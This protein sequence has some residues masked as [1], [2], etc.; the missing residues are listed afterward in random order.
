MT[1]PAPSSRRLAG[2]RLLARGAILFEA[3]WPALWPPIGLIG[4]FACAALLNLP[5]LL[6]PL[7]HLV[8][9][10]T[11]VLAV[12]VLA[13]RGL[14]GIRLP[15]DRAADRRLETSSGLIHR[16]LSVLTDR[17]A[18]GDSLGVAVWQAH[19]ARAMTQI[20]RLKVGLPRP[21]LARRDPRALRYGL[22]LCLLA[23]AV[24][25]GLDAP[26]RLLAALSPSLPV[27][28]NAP[29][30]EL[31]AWITAPAYTRVAPI[32]L[33]PPGGTVSVPAGSHLTVNVSGGTSAP[34]LSSNDRSDRFTALDHTSFQVER[35]LAHGGL[36]TVRRDGTTLAAWTLTV[37]ADQPPTAAWGENPGH[38]PSAQQTRLPWQVSDDY[39]VTGLQAELRLRDR[40]EAPPLIVRIP[41]PGGSPKDAHGLNQQDLTA[42]PWAGLPVVGQLIARDAANQTGASADATFDLAERPFHNPVAQLLIAMRKALSAHPDDRDVPLDGLDRL[43]QQ[44]A[45]FNGD[46]GAYLNL[47]SIYYLLARNPNASAVPEAQGAMWELALHMEEGQTEQSARQLEQARQAARD[48]LDRATQQPTDANRQALEKRLQELRQAI[49]KHMQALAEQAQRNNEMTPFDPNAAQ[50]SNRDLDKMAEQAQ[51]AARQGRMQDAQQQMAELEKML[52]RLRNAHSQSGGS[53]QANGQRQRGKQQMGAVQDM[54][55]REAGLMD[56]AQQRTEQN[57]AQPNPAQP[58]PTQSTDPA[59]Q[60]EADRRV[61][62]A[63]RRALGELMQQ[64]SDL[65]GQMP[66]SL[67]EADQAM[68]DSIGRLGQGDDVTAGRSQQQA[69][70]ALQKGS[71]EMGQTMAQQFGRQPG[72]GGEDGEEGVMGMM[73]PDGSRAD[74]RGPGPML[75][76]PDPADPNGRDPL[77]RS[78]Q[79]NSTDNADVTVPEERERQRT[80]AIQEELRRRG[81][82][83]ERPREELDYIDRLL[84]QF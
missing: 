52:D 23:A 55:G 45:L 58:N 7:A 15:D 16:P 60:R 2:R 41:L 9:L 19:A 69:I 18:G 49:D 13:V 14:R 79:G 30:T 21:G 67:G 84:K 32:F 47:S 56:H 64:F 70:A 62:Q 20:G 59:E 5:A 38:L 54:I 81:A 35:D 63:L 6:P 83:Q 74:G 27:A 36:L 72:Q 76:Q 44:P 10:L 80:Q 11:V 50:L 77:G 3:L 82:D 39:G 71:R 61:Q 37:V 51:Q 28:P 4:L 34:T 73:M 17:P 75:G 33:K 48:A 25:A 40:P 31:Q 12:A 66:P 46:L 57:P 53:K 22:V 42:H 8:L 78:A 1:D 65:T 24:I 68:R 43:M 26:A 29:G